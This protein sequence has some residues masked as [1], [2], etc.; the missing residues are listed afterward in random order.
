MA[1]LK[2]AHKLFLV[3]SGEYD[4]FLDKQTKT[5]QDIQMLYQAQDSFKE[6]V[7]LFEDQLALHRDHRSRATDFEQQQ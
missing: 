6:L 4:N 3:K 7:K 1:E 5:T 2:E